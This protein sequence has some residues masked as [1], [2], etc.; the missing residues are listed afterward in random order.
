MKNILETTGRKDVAVFGQDQV[1]ID[2]T[3]LKLTPGSVTYELTNRE[4]NR[5][6]R[7]E[8]LSSSRE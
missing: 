1:A 4:G 2:R 3:H 8:D 5:E 7:V 6:I